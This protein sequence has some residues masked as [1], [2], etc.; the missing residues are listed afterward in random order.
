MVNA[1]KS[2]GSSCEYIES[3]RRQFFQTCTCL[4]DQVFHADGLPYR[5]L[6]P[7]LV[8]SECSPPFAQF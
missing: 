6:L 3:A 7:S 1:I 5:P 2:F 4:G 8:L